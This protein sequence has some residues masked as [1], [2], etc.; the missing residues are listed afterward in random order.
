MEITAFG[1]IE[2]Q[3]TFMTKHTDTEVDVLLTKS[4]SRSS[5]FKC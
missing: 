1:N 4:N 2:G 5:D 3:I